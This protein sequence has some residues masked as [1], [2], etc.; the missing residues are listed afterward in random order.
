MDKDDS[1]KQEVAEAGAR[2]LAFCFVGLQASYLTWGYVQEKVMTRTYSTGKFPSATFCVFSNRILAVTVAMIVTMARHGC[3]LKISAPF[4]SFAPCALSN[5]LSSFGQYQ[6]LR[7]VSFP[8]QTISKSTKVIPVMLMGKFLNQK[9]YPAV[10][11]LEALV[12]SLGVS[13]FSLAGRSDDSR[14]GPG[15]ENDV[16]EAAMLVL[17]ISMLALYVVSDSFTSQW[18]SRVYSSHPGVD[19]FQMMF[20]VNSWA[21]V[22]TLAALLSS[23]ELWTTIDFFRLNPAAA[24]DNL[25]IAVTSATGQLFIFYT[26]KTFGPVV[27]TIIMTTRQVFSIVLSTVIFGHTITPLALVG[28]F[29][30]FAALFSRIKRQAAAKKSKPDTS[31]LLDSPKLKVAG[32]AVNSP[33]AS[34]SASSKTPPGSPVK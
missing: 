2:Q 3:R 4:H 34:S 26:I 28:A 29:V 1:K 18:Q 14:G 17:G 9:K 30:V 6:A 21:I 24:L 20:A 19:Q 22:M 11:Y 10:D 16:S 27:F 8:L 15:D 33:I 31:R 7:Y 25:T 32:G 12:I 13:I 23:G 5:S